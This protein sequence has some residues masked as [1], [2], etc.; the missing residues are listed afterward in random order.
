LTDVE[1]E[2]VIVP[3]FD[4]FDANMQ[5]F[6]THLVETVKDVVIFMVW[7]EILAIIEGLLIPQLSKFQSDMTQKPLNDKEVDIVFTWLKMWGEIAFWVPCWPD[8]C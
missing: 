3:F 5:I 4:Y 7:K 2:R 1:I 6:N 8:P